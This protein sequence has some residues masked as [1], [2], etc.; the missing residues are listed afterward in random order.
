[1]TAPIVPPGDTNSPKPPVRPLSRWDYRNF[2]IERRLHVGWVSEG[3]ALILAV[4]IA[5]GLSALLIVLSEADVGE[6]YKCKLPL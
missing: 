1:V 3:L 5:I 2:R 6:A 4:S